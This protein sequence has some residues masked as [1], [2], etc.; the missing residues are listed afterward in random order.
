MYVT[1]AA[2]GINVTVNQPVYIK[3]SF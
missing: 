2:N 3:C 1:D